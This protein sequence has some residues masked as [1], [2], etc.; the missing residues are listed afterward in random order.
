MTGERGR[1]EA[2]ANPKPMEYRV[3]RPESVVLPED[4]LIP[5]PNLVRPAPTR[6]THELLIAEPYWFDRPGQRDEP[7]GVLPAG[8]PVVVLVDGAE[9]SRVVDGAGRYVEVRT[10]S[11]RTLSAESP[12]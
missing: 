3:L 10:G 12:S 6:F 1:R 7:D 9:R 5:P 8:T 2:H 4:A 11:L